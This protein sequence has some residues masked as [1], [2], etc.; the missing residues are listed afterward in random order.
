VKE[1]QLEEMDASILKNY[2][3]AFQGL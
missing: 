1:S 2:G 3:C